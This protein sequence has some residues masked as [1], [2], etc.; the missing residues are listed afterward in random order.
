MGSD[1]AAG[2][3]LAG[4]LR[5]LANERP[6][7]EAFVFGEQRLSFGGLHQR[8]SRLANALVDAGVG[9]GDRVAVVLGNGIEFFEI[10]FGVSKADATLVALNWRL[11]PPEL[12]AILADAQPSLLIV[13]PDFA[14]KVPGV[15]E[16]GSDMRVVT[17]GDD[18]EEQL[19]VASPEDPDVASAPDNVM[20]VLYSSGTTGRP[21]GVMLTNANLAYIEVM[22]EQLFRMTPDSVHL[23]VAPLFH[24]G[25]A[26]TGLTTTTLGGRTVI[27]S[28]VK[29]DQVLETIEREG[30]THAF[31]VPAV[32][33]RLI[34]S[35]RPASAISRAWSTS[36]MVRRR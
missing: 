5:R 19:S 33:Q 28:E 31:F 29:A 32:I 7:H 10:A 25:G 27:L 22:A 1:P 23:V 26:G 24:I 30:V 9:P 20:L 13:D 8:S 12:A 2:W 3:S 16:R 35:P 6:D 14:G 21:K 11:S 18:Y 36:P 15:N 34:E 4:V 17:L